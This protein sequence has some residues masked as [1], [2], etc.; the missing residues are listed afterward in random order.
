MIQYIFKLL[1]I[2]FIFFSMQKSQEGD[3]VY[4]KLNLIS[5]IHT[6]RYD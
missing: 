6:F 3:L 4:N 5:H 1:K 2:K